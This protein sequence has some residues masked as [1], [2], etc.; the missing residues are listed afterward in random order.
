MVKGLVPCGRAGSTSERHGAFADVVIPIDAVPLGSHEDPCM[1]RE[2][3]L[4]N[5]RNREG[6]K[7]VVVLLLETPQKRDCY[8]HPSR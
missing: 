6:T 8:P 7:R 5:A 4:A 1:C 2:E 3:D